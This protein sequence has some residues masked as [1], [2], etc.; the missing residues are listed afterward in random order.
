MEAKGA[1]GD[2]DPQ[3]SIGALGIISSAHRLDHLARLREALS[4]C[5]AIH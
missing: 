3:P 2:D 4:P 1:D 5:C